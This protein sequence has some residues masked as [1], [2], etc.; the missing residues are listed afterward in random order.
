MYLFYFLLFLCHPSFTRKVS[1]AASDVYKILLQERFSPGLSEIHSFCYK[2]FCAITFTIIVIII[3][4][5]IIC[6]I[7]ARAICSIIC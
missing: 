7:E 2:I 5:I 3:I 6:V 4:V 1:S